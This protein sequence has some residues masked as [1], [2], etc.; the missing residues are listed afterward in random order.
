MV[1]LRSLDL[2]TQYLAAFF[3]SVTLATAGLNTVP[4]DG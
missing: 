4:L 2:G 1:I 3:Q